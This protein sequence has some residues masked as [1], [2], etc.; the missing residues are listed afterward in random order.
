MHTIKRKLD[1]IL[2]INLYF[3][4]QQPYLVVSITIR[5]DIYVSCVDV[6]STANCECLLYAIGLVEV[7]D[8]LEFFKQKLLILT[9]MSQ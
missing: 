7:N 5:T 4:F 1:I 3:Q 2:S 6:D 8:F 9:R